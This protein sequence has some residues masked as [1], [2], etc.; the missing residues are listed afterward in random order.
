[1]IRGT[2]VPLLYFKT[3]ELSMIK[4]KTQHLNKPEDGNYGKQFNY[5]C[6]DHDVNTCFQPGFFDT[7]TGNFMA[8]DTIKCIKIEKE[9]VVAVADGIVL[10]VQ[11]NG[12]V[13]TVDFRPV[14][15]AGASG[16]EGTT[17]QVTTFAGKPLIVDEET[18]VDGPEYIKENGTV[19]WNPGKKVFEVRVED[20]V[21]YATKEKPEALKIARGDQ[22]IP[23]AA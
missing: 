15:G 18:E 10:E 16:I 8:G 14:L 13:R 17:A 20:Q 11:I 22:P 9:R 6:K 23:V 2:P 1:M 12:N 19:K 4:A 3:G 21:V 7:L 5:I